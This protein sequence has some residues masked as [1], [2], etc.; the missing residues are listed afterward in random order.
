VSAVAAITAFVVLDDLE[1]GDAAIVRGQGFG[2]SALDFVVSLVV[3]AI[4]VHNLETH[5]GRA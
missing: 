2:G 5:D 3:A 4:L 1:G